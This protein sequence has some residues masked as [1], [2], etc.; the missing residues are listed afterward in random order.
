VLR[1]VLGKLHRHLDNPDYNLLVR[2]HPLES[3][4]NRHYHWYIVIIPKLATPAGFEISTGIYINSMKPED[5]APILR[6]VEPSEIVA[7]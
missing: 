4:A 3:R 6:E 1:T 7:C 2:S 5:A